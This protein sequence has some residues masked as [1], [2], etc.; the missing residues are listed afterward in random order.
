MHIKHGKKL[1][2]YWKVLAFSTGIAKKWQELYCSRS[3]YSICSIYNGMYTFS[4][5]KEACVG[6]SGLE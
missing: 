6:E 2:E 5:D 4:L 3:I 1:A